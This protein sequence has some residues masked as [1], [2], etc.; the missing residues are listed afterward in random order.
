MSH[1]M[2]SPAGKFLSYLDTFFVILV[3]I[4]NLS[5]SCV[6]DPSRAWLDKSVDMS[7]AMVS[8]AGKFLPHLDTFFVTGQPWQRKSTF[9]HLFLRRIIGHIF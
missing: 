3:N 1:A 4:A 9:D 8:L 2:V 5:R 6:F 7:H